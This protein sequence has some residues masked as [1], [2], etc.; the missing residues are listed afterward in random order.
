[1]SRALL[2]GKILGFALLGALLLVLG[3]W[4]RP[5]IADRAEVA[6]GLLEARGAP[7]VDLETHR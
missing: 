5:L 3:L 6:R 4:P 1:M 2:L 7:A